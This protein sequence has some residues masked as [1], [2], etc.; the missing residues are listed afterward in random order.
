[1]KTI[2]SISLACRVVMD[3]HALNNEGSESNRLMTRQVGIVTPAT[4]EQGEL[5][6]NS[7]GTMR[8]RRDVVNAISGDMNKHIF[9]DAFR[10]I[11][12]DLGLPMNRYSQALDPARMMADP[13]F[14]AYVEAKDGTKPKY[15]AE[16]VID[17]LISCAL[18]DVCGIMITAGGQSI[19][20]KSAVEFGWTVGLPEI[21]RVEEF[22]HARH[23][24]T[25]LT[26]FKAGKDA[27]QKDREQAAD[28]KAANTGQMIFNRPASS[29]VYAFVAHLDVGAIGFNDATQRYPDE[30]AIAY[31]ASGTVAKVQRTDRLRAALLALAQTVLH[32]K[33]AL[34]STQMPHVVDLEG[35]I[36]VSSSAAAAPLISPL[37]DAFIDRAHST[38]A[39]LN[40]LHGHDTVAVEAFAGNEG[41]LHSINEIVKNSDPGHYTR[42]S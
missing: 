40:E 3:L 31:N 30:V 2:K 7:N 16:E 12:L 32:P 6:T 23:A 42:V 14:L 21:T 24:I 11:G 15:S 38:A 4:N 36:S 26:R 35:F 37:S 5:E 19:K 25:R 27:E 28:E 20:R 18:T 8:Y 33:G 9:A 17:Q 39:L 29:G 10:S 34:T 22:I 13:D 41:L 1:M